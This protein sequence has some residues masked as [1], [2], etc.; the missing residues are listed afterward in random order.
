MIEQMDEV[1]WRKFLVISARFLYDKW[2]WDDAGVK[3]ALMPVEEILA[4]DDNDI[5]NI[6]YDRGNCHMAWVVG[7]CLVLTSLTDFEC[8]AIVDVV[9]EV[10]D[11]NS[12]Y[13][14]HPGFYE[15]LMDNIYDRPK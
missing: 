1:C 12:F 4:L 10:I 11:I 14:A 15:R 3:A 13:E 2:V 6:E 5:A 9:S 8:E 7:E